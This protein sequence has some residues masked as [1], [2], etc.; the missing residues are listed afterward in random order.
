MGVAAVAAG[1]AVVQRVRSDWTVGRLVRAR[2]RSSTPFRNRA[3]RDAWRQ[4]YR[5]FCN[6]WL[7]RHQR[8]ITADLLPCLEEPGPVVLRERAA[9]AL[10]RLESPAAEAPLAA[11]LQRVQRSDRTEEEAVPI[12]TVELALARIR[13]RAQP[14]AARVE[15]LAR[16][17]GLS[18]SDLSLLSQ[19]VNDSRSDAAGTPGYE[20]IE[21]VVDLLYSLG[22]RGADIHPL[23]ERLVLSPAQQVKLKAASLPLEQEVTL[24]LNHLSNVSVLKGDDYVLM[25]HLVG[26]GPIASQLLIQRLD[27]MW[28]QP[29]R[30][31]Q[32]RGHKVLFRAVALTADEEAV[33]VLR[34]FGRH[35]NQYI[36]AQ[37]RIAI[38]DI[39]HQSAFPTLP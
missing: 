26:L 35:P 19:R 13:S 4:Q 28:H 18:T 10:G 25:H 30:Y 23:T 17:V 7:E 29:S 2:E 21:E 24:L 16:S 14:V 11:L 12:H 1:F 5:R 37:A 31:P 27:E 38:Q 9:R 33:P 32:P 20:T 34:Q 36:S 15:A 6:L 39:Q 3:E 22:K 8:D